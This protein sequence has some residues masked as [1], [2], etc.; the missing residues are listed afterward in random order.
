M[1][2]FKN[3][4]YRV[5]SKAPDRSR[6]SC[7]MKQKI[8]CKSRLVSAGSTVYVTNFK[9]NHAPTFEGDLNMLKGQK[10]PIMV[11][12]QYEYKVERQTTFTNMCWCCVAKEKY[13][14][15]A[16][17]ITFHDNVVIKRRDHNHPPTFKGDCAME[18]KSVI[19]SYE[20]RKTFTRKKVAKTLMRRTSKD[21]GEVV[22]YISKYDS[23]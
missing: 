3:F 7:K 18:P 22:E 14:C 19:I 4:E 6:W 16:R 1:L 15:K 11:L 2:I 13:K 17:I 5:E 21:D 9:H 23:D 12:G 20:P 8:K 10:R